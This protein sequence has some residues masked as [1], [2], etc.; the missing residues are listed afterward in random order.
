DPE[1]DVLGEDRPSV[2]VVAHAVG[3]P[4]GLGEGLDSVR[5]APG[6]G[7]RDLDGFVT[8]PVRG[9][10]GEGAADHDRAEPVEFDVLAAGHRPRL[11]SGFGVRIVVD[12]HQQQPGLGE[13]ERGHVPVD[14]FDVDVGVDVDEVGQYRF[15]EQGVSEYALG[16]LGIVAGRLQIVNENL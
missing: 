9:G 4:T 11:R 15:I 10:I 8:G 12:V 16:Q 5:R 7:E 2:S 13:D 1:H 14:G 3:V 6:Q